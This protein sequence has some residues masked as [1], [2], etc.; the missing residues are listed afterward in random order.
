MVLNIRQS[1]LLINQFNNININQQVHMADPIKYVLRPFEG[2]INPG[3]PTGIKLYI[4]SKKD[5][6]KEADKL[7]ILDTNAKDTKYHF[8]SIANKY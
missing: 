2:N 7:Y 8:L 5:I 4:K 6:D 1:Q 3:Y